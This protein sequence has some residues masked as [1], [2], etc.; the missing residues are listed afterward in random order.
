MIKDKRSKRGT[1]Q[2]SE[3]A[4]SAGE[5][6]SAELLTV[7]LK[8]IQ[9]HLTGKKTKRKSKEEC[10]SILQQH[11]EEAE[12]ATE[13]LA[14]ELSQAWSSVDRETLTELKQKFT[15]IGLKVEDIDSLENK[16]ELKERLVETV[17]TLTELTGAMKE[18][19]EDLAQLFKLRTEQA[20]EMELKVDP[21]NL[22]SLKDKIA[23][24]VKKHKIKDDG[25]KEGLDKLTNLIWKMSSNY[26]LQGSEEIP[27]R[28]EI[29]NLISKAPKN[30]M[31]GLLD[32]R[33]HRIQKSS[34]PS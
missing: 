33:K 13:E 32:E 15:A 29:E 10:A 8:D 6:S 22:A 16:L 23:E 19:K 5:N 2:T 28:K 11:K 31:S 20:L 27:E 17:E 1:A 30:V 4:P 26:L 3:V 25:M 7:S 18:E 9:A 34:S 14:K 12:K 24:G 21:G